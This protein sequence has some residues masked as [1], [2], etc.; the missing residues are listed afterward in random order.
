VERARAKQSR[1]CFKGSRRNKP[2]ALMVHDVMSSN[3][4]GGHLFLLAFSRS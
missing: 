3:G 2:K 1:G 4:G